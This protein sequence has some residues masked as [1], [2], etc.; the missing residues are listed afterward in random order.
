[1]VSPIQKAVRARNIY[2]Y[3]LLAFLLFIVFSPILYVQIYLHDANDF[4]DHLKFTNQWIYNRA[5]IPLHILAHPLYQLSV[6]AVQKVVSIPLKIFHLKSIQLIHS[7]F[8]TMLAAFL[9]Q[10]MLIFALI[11]TEFNRLQPRINLWSVLIT[12]ALMIVTPVTVLAL[13]DQELYFG[14][15]GITTY[16]NPT[17]ILLKPFALASFWFAGNALVRSSTS[18]KQIL[19]SALICLASVLTKPSFVICL[20][21]ALGLFLFARF[22][23]TRQVNWKLAILGIFIPS[24]LVLIWQYALTYGEDSSRVILMPFSTMSLFSQYLLPK[25]LLSI[26]FPICVSIIYRK[27]VLQNRWMILAWLIFFF[28]ALYTYFFA[29]S[30]KRFVDINFGWSGDIAAYLLFI[31]STAFFIRLKSINKQLSRADTALI[32]LFGL[33]LIAGMVYYAYCL[34]ANDISPLWQLVQHPTFFHW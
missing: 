28:G 24:V 15:L 4:P 12:L 33:H 16:H 14:Y 25:F 23:F 11:K 26:L 31:V 27:Q 21:P 19:L 34:F 2:F 29:E 22:L 13:K 9:L 17:I 5:E 30:G 20:L 10:G 6:I 3:L 8:I 32:L 7:S 1:M 18:W